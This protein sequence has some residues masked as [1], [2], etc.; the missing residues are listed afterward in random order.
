[1]SPSVIDIAFQTS[2]SIKIPILIICNILYSG[3]QHH[4][5]LS[6]GKKLIAL[7]VQKIIK[8]LSGI[9]STRY[10]IETRM[11]CSYLAEILTIFI[12]FFCHKGSQ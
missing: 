7:L 10:L 12:E 2:Q 8:L 1:M 6:P 5:L 9:C 11:P 3:Y 4:E